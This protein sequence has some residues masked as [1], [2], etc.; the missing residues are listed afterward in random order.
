MREFLISSLIA[1]FFGKRIS[2]DI[3]DP[4]GKNTRNAHLPLLKRRDLGA[5]GLSLKT[6]T[7]ALSCHK[8]TLDSRAPRVPRPND[9]EN[10]LCHLFLLQLFPI[11]TIRLYT[12]IFN[13]S[14]ARRNSS[15]LTSR[16]PSDRGKRK[17]RRCIVIVGLNDPP[18]Y[19]SYERVT[20]DRKWRVVFRAVSSIY[21]ALSFPRHASSRFVSSFPR[22]K[23]HPPYIFDQFSKREKEKRKA[24]H[25]DEGGRI[26]TTVFHSFSSRFDGVTLMA[27]IGPPL[28]IV[29]RV[30]DFL[31]SRIV[32][33]NF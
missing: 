31:E 5:S 24:V 19:V 2:K 10:M 15:I 22:Q 11:I 32:H 28:F 33:S 3:K 23:F 7:R 21:S 12:N 16:F 9:L 20:L 26:R 29:T 4:S 17:S 27:S 6:F 8:P 14:C 30:R 13:F 25:L 18:V 1:D